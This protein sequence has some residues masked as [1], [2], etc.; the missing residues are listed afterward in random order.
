LLETPAYNTIMDQYFRPN[1]YH[2]D[3]NA[4]APY[5]SIETPQ[6]KDGK[7]ISYDDARLAREKVLYAR[8]HGLGGVIIWE[9]GDGYRKS[10][11]AGHRDA[12]LQVVKEAAHGPIGTSHAGT[13]H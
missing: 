2:W 11:P 10:Q 3:A 8:T 12:L 5:L 1:L 6:S 7:F 9:L 4:H 13:A